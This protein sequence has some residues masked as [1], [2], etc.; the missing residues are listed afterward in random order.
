M[1]R[2]SQTFVTNP[3]KI[4]Y[5][6]FQES[7]GKKTGIS[8][9][10]WDLVSNKSSILSSSEI[11]KYSSELG[12]PLPEMIFGNSFVCVE[13]KELGIQIDFSSI[14]SLRCVA[15]ADE[16]SLIKVAYSQEWLKEREQWDE[17]N[18]AA[19]P[20]DWTY[21]TKYSGTLTFGA[22][23]QK[24]QD[25][26][27]RID[28]EGLKIKEPIYFYTDNILFED[29]LG[30][31]GSALLNVKAR[32][33]PSGFF[34]LQR[35][36]LRVDDVLYRFYD[37]RVYHRFETNKIIKE[38]SSREFEYNHVSKVLE[39]QNLNSPPGDRSYLAD[40]NLVYSC[41]LNLSP[42]PNSFHCE[43]ITW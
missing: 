38:Y 11:D 36:S 5:K 1:N 10:G 39:K 21:S 17:I 18:E 23:C 3:Q 43:N 19:P 20:F 26:L 8:I 30:D 28:L 29:E 12:F 24:I 37:T 25:P 34:I 13:N 41:M 33:M 7:D 16:S 35:F 6:T 31:N 22:G 14:D 40:M 4:N 32:V 9:R 15:K 42:E 2:E 27:E